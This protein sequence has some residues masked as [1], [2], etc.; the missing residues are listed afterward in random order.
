MLRKA[1]R[2]IVQL[3]NDAT[4]S[5]QRLSQ[6]FRQKDFNG[7]QLLKTK[8][9]IEILSLVN[10]GAITHESISQVINR[11]KTRKL[12][13]S[14]K[15]FID[16]K[17]FQ[18]TLK[19]MERIT[20]GTELTQ[21]RTNM[22]LQEQQQLIYVEMAKKD[23]HFKK[24]MELLL[25]IPGIGPDTAAIVL[26][27][28]ADISYFDNPASLAKWAGLAPKVYQ[29]GHKKNVTGKI[30]K[31][32]NKYLRRALAL[33]T[34]NIYAK[35]KQN[36]LHQWMRDKKE[37]RESKTNESAYWLVIC[38]GARKLLVY[39]YHILKN[40]CLWK[41]M[42]VPEEVVEKV[43]KYIK[44]KTRDF[45]KKVLQLEHAKSLISREATTILSGLAVPEI[46]PKY[47]LYQILKQPVGYTYT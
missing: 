37:V 34:Q 43:V 28:L 38:V 41:L 39:V 3:I 9:G 29:S 16:V 5:K 12:N 10:N 24:N 23:E 7:T 18:K 44:K 46:S 11:S 1:M 30:H 42:E 27:E 22:L 26:S 32:G 21:L 14:E 2:K 6:L 4:R 35:A 31:S 20:F 47:L 40:Q 17:T 19:S 33:A 45:Q 36:P 13:L 15:D 25:S 8:M